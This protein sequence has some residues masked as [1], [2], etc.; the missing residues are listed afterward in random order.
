MDYPRRFIMY[1]HKDLTGI[2]G[3]GRVLDG[4]MFRNG[5]VVVS[6]LTYT[7][8][9]NIYD[10]LEAFKSVHVDNHGEHANEIV[11]LDQDE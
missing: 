8:S 11:W 3:T 5:R 1:R 7:H 6:W 9:I 10:S 4:V 2:S